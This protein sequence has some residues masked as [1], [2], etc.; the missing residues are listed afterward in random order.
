MCIWLYL[1]L[2]LDI[3]S[4]CGRSQQVFSFGVNWVQLRLGASKTGWSLSTGRHLRAQ[5]HCSGSLQFQELEG[6]HLSALHIPL[7]SQRHTSKTQV[8]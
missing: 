2:T 1:I 7:L 5:S 3:D 8:P 6:R 4:A